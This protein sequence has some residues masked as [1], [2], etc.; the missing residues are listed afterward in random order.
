MATVI[1]SDEERPAIAPRENV[2]FVS[3]FEKDTEEKILRDEKQREKHTLMTMTLNQIVE[4][5]IKVVA[6]FGHEYTKHIYQVSQD[7]KLR[8]LQETFLNKLKLYL[9]A[10]VNYLGEKDNILYMGIILCFVSIIIY[11]FNISTS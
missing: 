9:F 6:M 1:K 8:G 10:F 3:E 5:T 11:F 2:V 7:H 4:N